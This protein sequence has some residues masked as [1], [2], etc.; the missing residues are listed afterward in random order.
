MD[1]AYKFLRGTL[2]CSGELGLAVSASLVALHWVWMY[3]RR[4]RPC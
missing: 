3:A 4:D 1:R 2:E